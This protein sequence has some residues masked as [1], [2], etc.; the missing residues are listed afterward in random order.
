MANIP[1]LTVRMEQGGSSFRAVLLFK[2]FIVVI[3][4]MHECWVNGAQSLS[5]LKSDT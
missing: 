1:V 3:M 5:L 2:A 4:R